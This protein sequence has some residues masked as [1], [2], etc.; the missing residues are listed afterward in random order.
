M[1]TFVVVDCKHQ[2]NEFV[3]R[4][5]SLARRQLTVGKRIEVWGHIGLIE[6][7]YDRNV[8]M[9]RPYMD[10]ERAYKACKAQEAKQ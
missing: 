2:R 6:T 9:M 3:T 10:D 1:H 5:P 8:A 7:I 4:S